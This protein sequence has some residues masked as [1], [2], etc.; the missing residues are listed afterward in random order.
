MND[1]RQRHIWPPIVAILAA[2]HRILSVFCRAIGDGPSPLKP[3]KQGP[4]ECP[5][6]EPPEGFMTHPMT[7]FLVAAGFTSA[8]CYLLITRAQSRRAQGL[9]VSQASRKASRASSRDSSAAD[10]GSYSSDSAGWGWFGH[11]DSSGHAT[12]SCGPGNAGGDSG[13][14]GDCGGGGGGD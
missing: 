9:L 6:K 13:S 11:S 3:L 10:A 7:V 5:W 8:V 4:E 12:D 14:S 1:E 2:E